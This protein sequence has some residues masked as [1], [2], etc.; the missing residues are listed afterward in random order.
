VTAAPLDGVLVVAVEQAVAA[1]FA[2]RQ[3][4]DLG[5]R[6]IKIERPGTGDFARH[7][8]SKVNGVSSVFVWL[9]RGKESVELDIKS[10]GG[11]TVL[12]ALLERADVFIHN[13]A[14]DAAKALRLDPATLRNRFPELI[15]AAVSGYGSSGPLA[16]SKAYDLLVQGETGLMSLNGDE[17]HYARVGISIA[18]ISAG[19]YAYASV[20]AAL[21]HRSQTGQSLPVDVSLFDSLAEWLSYPLYSTMHSGKPPRRTGTRHGAI[22][23]YGAY[24]TA[25]GEQVLLA[26]QNDAEWRR[27]CVHVLED[28]ALAD[29]PSFSSHERRVEQEAELD[30]RIN[31]ALEPLDRVTVLAR[32]AAAGIACARVNPIEQLAAHEQLASEERWTTTGTESGAVRTLLPPWVPDGRSG[33]LG[34]VPALGQHTQDVLDWLRSEDGA[35]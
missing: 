8:D 33:D 23:P 31:A 29:D 32:L 14:P 25:G 11:R 34:A 35:W 4:A 15:P 26:V 1:P 5:A 22:V 24:P 30:R 27:F 17:E 7:Y 20:L 3:L 13:I 10:P 12:D 6:V 16:S 21:Y 9:N 19:M 18:D 2:T 28:P